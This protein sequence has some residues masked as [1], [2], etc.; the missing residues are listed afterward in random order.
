MDRR[1]D[2]YW[3]EGTGPFCY[4]LTVDAYVLLNQ[5]VNEILNGLEEEE[6][7][8]RAAEEILTKKKNIS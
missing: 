1:V 7:Q 2:S 5:Y 3:L 8:G 4:K 6:H